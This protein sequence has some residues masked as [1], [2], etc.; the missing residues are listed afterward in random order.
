[1]HANKNRISRKIMTLLVLVV[2]SVMFLPTIA[3]AYSIG[4]APSVNAPSAPSVT[5]QNPV[6]L[7]ILRDGSPVLSAPLMAGERVDLVLERAPALALVTV[8]DDQTGL[9]LASG[10]SDENGTVVLFGT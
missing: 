2:A 3:I 8:T 4:D 5:T 7:A 6:V 1:M 9:V 10:R